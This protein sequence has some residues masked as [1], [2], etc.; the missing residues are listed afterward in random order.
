M[1]RNDLTPRDT[2]G[3]RLLIIDEIGYLSF[4]EWEQVFGGNTALTSAMLDR[5]PL[6]PT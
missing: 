6:M 3:P 5:L 4:G 2:T 1:S